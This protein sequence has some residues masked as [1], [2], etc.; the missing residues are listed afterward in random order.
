MRILTR[1]QRVIDIAN[2]SAASDER[3][4]EADAFLF[5]K[6]DHLDAER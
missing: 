6:A 3:R 5:R 2:E 1:E 4:A